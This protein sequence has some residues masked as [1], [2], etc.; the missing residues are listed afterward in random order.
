MARARPPLFVTEVKGVYV[1]SSPPH[2]YLISGNTHK[3]SL[4]LSPFLKISH[5]AY[6]GFFLI[7]RSAISIESLFFFI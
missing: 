1:K 3:T 7:C 4:L 6:S 5:R 2:V